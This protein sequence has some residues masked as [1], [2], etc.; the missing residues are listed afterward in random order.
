MPTQK[1]RMPAVRAATRPRRRKT[2][3]AP[4]VRAR[5]ALSSRLPWTRRVLELVDLH[6]SFG[7]RRALDGL[8]FSVPKGSLCG[9]VGRNGAGKTTAMRVVCGLVRPDRGEVR[10]RG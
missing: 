5:S 8:S 10:W 7:E 6:R 4:S 2:V 1:Q 9:L 3:I